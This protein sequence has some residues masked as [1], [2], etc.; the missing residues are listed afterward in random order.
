MNKSD[1]KAMKKLFG[2]T[3]VG[4]TLQSIGSLCIIIASIHIFKIVN[5]K[6]REVFLK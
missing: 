2:L 6:I 4:F 1:V 5:E 3:A